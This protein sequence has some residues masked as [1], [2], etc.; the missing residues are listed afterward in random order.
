MEL[1]KISDCCAMHANNNQSINELFFKR[2]A[3]SFCF[4]SGCLHIENDFTVKRPLNGITGGKRLDVLTLM[5][6]FKAAAFKKMNRY[7]FSSS[8]PKHRSLNM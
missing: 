3:L 8:P 4:L 2:A 5:A 6:Q 7:H 1:I